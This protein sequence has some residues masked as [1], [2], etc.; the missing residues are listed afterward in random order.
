M[1]DLILSSSRVVLIKRAAEPAR[2]PTEERAV[3]PTATE[4][5]VPDSTDTRKEA[6]H[7]Q[8]LKSGLERGLVSA[9]RAT[10]ELMLESLAKVA[11]RAD[12]DRSY[13][14]HY[15]RQLTAHPELAA[16]LD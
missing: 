2:A 3:A 7:K 6:E 15:V 13:E 11:H 4:A 5:L 10:A 12:P 16:L 9:E 14:Q 1:Q 8:I